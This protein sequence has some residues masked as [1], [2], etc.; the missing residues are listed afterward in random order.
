M[1]GFI[2]L[3]FLTGRCVVGGPDIESNDCANVIDKLPCVRLRDSLRGTYTYLNMYYLNLDELIATVRWP[4]GLRRQTK[5][6]GSYCPVYL[7]LRGVG[8]N[9]TLIRFFASFYLVSRKKTFPKH[10]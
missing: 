3:V 1:N 4:S 9:P 10:K 2:L 6:Q 8:S 7:V 5:D